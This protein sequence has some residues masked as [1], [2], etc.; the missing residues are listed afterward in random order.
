MFAAAHLSGQ[1]ATPPPISILQDSGSLADGLVFIGP[2]TTASSQPS[3][4]EILD[5]QGRMVWFNAVPSGLVATDFRVQTY[6]GLPVLTWMQSSAFGA[7]NPEPSVGYILDNTYSVVAKV[8]ASNL[9]ADQHEFQLTP[10]NTA[11]LVVYN[12]LQADL[13]SVGGS[14]SGWVT[15]GVVQEVDVATGNLLF[16]WHSLPNVPVTESYAPVPATTTQAAP[17]DY[18]HV[19]SAKLDTD[20]NL[21]ISSRHTWTVYKV[22]RS[23]GAVIWRLGGKKSDFALGP[24]LP[25]AWQHDAEA[26]DSSTIRVFDNESNGAPVL[27]YSR[28]LW[29]KHDDTAMTATIV[30]SIV[31]P[32]Q[33]SVLAEGSA[34]GLSNGN[35]FVEWG[36]LG[37]YSEF[38][39]DGQLLYDAAQAP[40]YSSYRGYRFPWTATASA[41]PTVTAV[42]NSDGTTTVH[43][44]WNGATGV[45]TWQLLVGASSGGLGA[46]ATA[47]WN[48]LDTEITIQG[49]V[50]AVGVNALDA[51]GNIISQS[52]PLSGPFPA[53]FTTEPVSQT[54][55]TGTTVVFSASAT[56]SSPSYQWLLNG[57]SLVDGT[58]NGV[59]ISG[60]AGPRLVITGATSAN[61]GQ[62]T[63]TATILGNQET[64][65]PA[66]LEIVGT[67]DIGRLTNVSARAVVG[68]GANELIAG[69]VVGGP[70]PSATLGLLIRASGP[71]LSGF[72]VTGVLPDPDLLLSL[73]SSS[74]LNPRIIQAWAG[75]TLV[76]E[77][78]AAVG[79]F[80]WTDPNSL[81]AATVHSFHVGQHTAQVVGASG[82]T[83]VALAEV[84]DAT[85]A[86]SYTPS[87]PRLINLSARAQVGTGGDALIA[88]FVIGGETSKTV[89]IRASGPAL[90]SFGISGVLPDPQLRLAG[91]SPG[92]IQLASGP[93]G[94]DP[95]ISA[96]AA[97][98]GAF[99]WGSSASLDSAILVTLPPGAYTA[100]VSG[101]SGDTGVALVEVYEVP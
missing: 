10:Q 33:L 82:D 22:N 69:Y 73:A 15:E 18:F 49:I 87:S 36:I 4:A 70:Q 9:N 89:L 37:R 100:E 5:N 39:P 12:T 80:A 52:V 29:V 61:A 59:T 75:S 48:G 47:P 14:T 35:T 20:G 97:R 67:D 27:P 85:P 90:A 93:W 81:D 6:K 2:T 38:G 23:T 41:G 77:T 45:A 50:G 32:A 43:A 28:V 92:T 78:A 71:A 34:Q 25:F 66:S 68:T 57:S 55:V 58:F 13:S 21:L 56:G 51:S 64:A 40:G 94:G 31:H 7:V 86:G 83:G 60:S 99:G 46:V 16:E 76:A 42:Q 91:S 53:A 96:A 44:I 84:Y 11:L 26:V 30:Q 8:A 98:A 88:G 1:T 3:G 101:L 62:Y 19:N 79:A 95:Q 17:Y 65:D 63:C 74:F 54:I 72:G 24:G